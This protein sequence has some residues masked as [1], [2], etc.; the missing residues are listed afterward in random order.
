MTVKV[1]DSQS[2]LSPRLL[3]KSDDKAGRRCQ[4][5]LFSLEKRY[6]ERLGGD[7]YRQMLAQGAIQAYEAMMYDVERHDHAAK[8]A[9]QELLL[10]NS[11]L[12]SRSMVLMLECW[13][14]G[15]VPPIM[16][17]RLLYACDQP[18]V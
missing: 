3:S 17:T 2:L 7:P 8:R 9:W 12:G 13:R 15:K 1:G 6:P 11:K 18:R 14:L 5:K 16:E 4:A 10:Q